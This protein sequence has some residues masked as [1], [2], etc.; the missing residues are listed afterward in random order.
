M[1][2]LLKTFKQSTN[3]TGSLTFIEAQRDVPF[4]I[5]RVYYIYNVAGNARRGFHAHRELKQFLICISGSCS[6]DLND[7]TTTRT[8]R[9]QDPNIGV[10]V[11]PKMW[12][13]MYDFAEGTVLLVLAS[14]YYS[15]PDYIRNYEEFL[16]FVKSE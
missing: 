16:Q 4:E 13:E 14:G 3:N 9:L 2:D 1:E 5:K 15:E 10:Y 11:G 12:H 6:V 8:V 7:G